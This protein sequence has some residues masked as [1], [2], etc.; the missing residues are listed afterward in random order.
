MAPKV[1][2][3]MDFGRHLIGSPTHSN[4]KLNTSEGGEVLASSVILSFNSPVIDNMTTTLHMTSVDMLE[5]GK[6]AVQLFVDAAYSGTAEGITQELFRDINKMANVFEVSWLIKKCAGYFTKAADS[7]KKPSYSKLLY[8]F[9]E[10]AFVSESLKT[11]DFLALA[12]EKIKM[13]K[14]EQQFIEKYLDNAARLST[15]RLDIVIELAGTEVNF[16]VQKLTS[17][18]SELVLEHGLPNHCQYLL[19]NSDLSLCRENN[20]VIFDQLFDVLDT[21]P[22]DMLRWTHNL[23]RRSTK[24]RVSVVVNQAS[25]PPKPNENI[26]GTARG[27]SLTPLPRSNLIPNL[28]HSF[29]MKMSLE[30]LFQWL[31]V[32]EV[33]TNL[34]MALEAAVHW[35]NNN[36]N[37]ASLTPYDHQSMKNRLEAL[38]K[39]RSWQILPSDLSTLQLGH[40]GWPAT[41]DIG[42]LCSR[43]LT[44]SYV[45]ILSLNMNSDRYFISTLGDQNKWKFHFKHPSVTTCNLPGECGFIIKTVAG[46]N[47]GRVIRALELC[48]ETEDYTNETVHFHEEIRAENMHVYCVI[49]HG[50]GSSY[51]YPISWLGI[52]QDYNTA[53]TNEQYHTLSGMRRLGVLY[54]I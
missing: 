11:K 54:K 49:E 53:L 5:F 44:S 8:L 19:D 48:T 41:A 7:V 21:L 38:R 24:M 37:Y 9:E 34:M 13:L 50:S 28:Y 51:L 14:F 29:D 46:N 10:A 27:S 36:R 35:N 33:V 39:R 43:S 22:D 20:R 12:L 2:V 31:S 6:A 52:F 32:S 17:Q 42:F 23:L 3:P 16:V 47:Y 15:Q 40:V 26:V 1:C 25:E 4:L 30:Q 45:S 18:L